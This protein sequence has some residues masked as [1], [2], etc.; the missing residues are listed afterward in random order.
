MAIMTN[1]DIVRLY[2]EQNP[3]LAERMGYDEMTGEV[4][5]NALSRF[6]AVPSNAN[7]FVSD[8]NNVL[9]NQIVFDT[10]K[11]W[12]ARYTWAQY[13]V[14]KYGDIEQFLSTTI[15]TPEE[16]SEDMSPF[17]KK[18]PTIIEQFMTTELKK[19]LPRS[20]SEEIFAG[21]F[22]REGGLVGLVS[23]ILKHLRDS[24]EVFMYEYLTSYIETNITKT[25]VL[26]TITGAGD[27]ANA[28]TA[29]EELI[30]LVQ[31]MSLPNTLYNEE[32]V[33]TLTPVGSGILILNP[34][35]QASFDV[36]VIASLFNSKEIG[37][38]KYFKQIDIVQFTDPHVI[39]VYADSEFLRWGLRIYKM[40][41][42]YNPA[43]LFYNYFLH[44]WVKVALVKVRQAVLLVDSDYQ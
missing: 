10:M 27:T 16:Y 2:A 37:A 33:K 8:L 6:G 39:G 28:Q 15:S 41:S 26:T 43:N 14:E 38:N 4:D 34:K 36:N 17:V 18:K 29:Y 35:T 20:I 23:I 44:F 7:E 42:I 31:D 30:T 22:T 12:N 32:S 40:A 3:V 1:A 5:G 13:D 11:G 9:V 24:M 25:K 19:V 21:A